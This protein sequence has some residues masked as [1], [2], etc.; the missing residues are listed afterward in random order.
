VLPTKALRSSASTVCILQNETA[1]EDHMT[2]KMGPCQ[3]N[4]SIQASRKSRKAKLTRTYLQVTGRL[5]STS[6][7]M[8]S[9]NR[10]RRRHHT[11]RKVATRRASAVC[12]ARNVFAICCADKRC[13]IHICISIIFSSERASLSYFKNLCMLALQCTAACCLALV[14]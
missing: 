5:R 1:I 4:C 7:L 3:Y 9:N 2:R 8:R 11:L 12:K 13:Y 10:R 14:M 6:D